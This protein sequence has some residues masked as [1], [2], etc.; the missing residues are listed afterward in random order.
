MSFGR[1][2]VRS[3]NL[4]WSQS[5]DQRTNDTAVCDTLRMGH[6]RCAVHCWWT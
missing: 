1:K 5:V 4:N 2:M 3:G 6:G